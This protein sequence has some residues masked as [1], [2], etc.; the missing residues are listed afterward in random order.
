MSEHDDFQ[1]MSG[2]LRM[3]MEEIHGKLER[4]GLEAPPS[5]RQGACGRCGGRGYVVAREGA[6]A[7][8]SLC[9]CD[10]RC[11][12]CNGKGLTLQTVDGYQFAR[13]CEC[14]TLP[15]RVAAFNAAQLPSRFAEKTFDDFYVHGDDPRELVTAKREMMHF[16]DTARPGHSRLGKGLLGKPGTGKT[17]LLSAALARM[18]LGRGISC[19][20][21]EISFLFADL[22]AAISDPRARA[23]VDKID[24]LAEVDVLAIDELGKGRGSV[25]EEEVLDELIGRRYNSGKLT[26]FATNYA[27]E[28]PDRPVSRDA[29][30]ELSS[31]SLRGRVGER[32]FSRLHEMVEFLDLPVATRDRRLPPTFG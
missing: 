1:K 3:L 15:Q 19:R 16:A 23:T 28:A 12:L 5:E 8:A 29:K 27:R 26:L 24:A 14:Q 20:Y 18:T 22:K 30:P 13:A 9:G 32:V 2:P 6:V 21:I 10:R 11:R 25:F 31:L 7:V 4:Q 17:H